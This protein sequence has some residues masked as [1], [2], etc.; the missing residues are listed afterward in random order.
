MAVAMP[1]LNAYFM[2]CCFRRAPR[3]HKDC[4]TWPMN[5]RFSRPGVWIV[6]GACGVTLGKDAALWRL[7]SVK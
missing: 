3:A 1:A 7:F 4:F 5:V 6:F 2:S